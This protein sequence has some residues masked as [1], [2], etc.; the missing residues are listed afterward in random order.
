MNVAIVLRPRRS[1]FFRPDA[2]RPCT[3]SAPCDK[4]IGNTVGGV[5]THRQHDLLTHTPEEQEQDQEYSSGTQTPKR[6][7]EQA[8]RMAALSDSILPQQQRLLSLQIGAICQNF[9]SAIKQKGEPAD[10]G[11]MTA[12]TETRMRMRTGKKERG[13]RRRSGKT[14]I[15]ETKTKKTSRGRPSVQKA[16]CRK[17]LARSSSGRSG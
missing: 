9:I 13:R 15:R 2:K 8:G 6:Q 11:R 1:V 17:L 5:C 12:T 16:T 10:G 3:G 4:N 14:K 7:R